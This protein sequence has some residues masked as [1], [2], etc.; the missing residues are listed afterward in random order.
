MAKDNAVV[1]YLCSEDSCD[2][3]A[4]EAGNVRTHEANIQFTKLF[5]FCKIA[6]IILTVINNQ[7]TKLFDFCKI[8]NIIL[9]AINNWLITA[10]YLTI[11]PDRF[12]KCNV[13]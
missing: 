2:Y 12:G 4:K 11:S 9:T 10:T 13:V 7:F 3:K 6:N 5:D 1:Y 8:A